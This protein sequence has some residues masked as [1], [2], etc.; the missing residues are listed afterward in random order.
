MTA[1]SPGKGSTSSKGREQRDVFRVVDAFGRLREGKPTRG[2]LS[3]LG[4]ILV[5][6]GI[7]TLGGAL[8]LEPARRM[9]LAVAI[10]VVLIVTGAAIIIYAVRMHERLIVHRWTSGGTCLALD[11]DDQLAVIKSIELPHGTKDRDV[12]LGVWVG[13]RCYPHPLRV[14]QKG[15]LSGCHLGLGAECDA[16]KRFRV[17]VYS[18]P[19]RVAAPIEEYYESASSIGKYPGM[20]EKEWPGGREVSELFAFSCVRQVSSERAATA[21][22]GTGG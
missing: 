10:D 4:I 13:G 11:G 20:A 3:A 7:V 22:G 1:A 8:L 15:T 6:F 9:W 5:A 21:Q 16:G 2:D 14:H 17:V 19:P 12:W 18:M